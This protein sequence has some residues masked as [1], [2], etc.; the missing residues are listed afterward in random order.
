MVD[1]MA[2][3]GNDEQEEIVCTGASLAIKADNAFRKE[4]ALAEESLAF[5]RWREIVRGVPKSKFIYLSSLYATGKV[6]HCGYG[7]HG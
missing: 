3:Q 4:S 1:G 6:D 2:E 5:P 7:C